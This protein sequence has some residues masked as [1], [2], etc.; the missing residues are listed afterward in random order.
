MKKLA[1]F[2]NII[3]YI[4]SYQA[5]YNKVASLIREKSHINIKIIELFL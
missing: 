3:D 2:E 5:M 1:E 4:S